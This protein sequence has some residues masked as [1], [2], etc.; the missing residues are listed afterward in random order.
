M[1]FPPLGLWVRP[2]AAPVVSSVGGVPAGGR[3]AALPFVWG[4]PLQKYAI[5]LG[6]AKIGGEIFASRGRTGA[7][8]HGAQKNAEAAAS[9]SGHHHGVRFPI[10]VIYILFLKCFLNIV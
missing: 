10:K 4:C 7:G 1:V 2:R 9:A 3:V 8:I 6:T 5:F